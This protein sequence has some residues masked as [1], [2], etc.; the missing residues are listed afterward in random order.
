MIRESDLPP[1]SWVDV[2]TLA[3]LFDDCVTSYKYFFFLALLDRISGKRGG[4]DVSSGDRPILLRELAVDMVVAA[5]Y[6]HGFCRLSFGLQDR[7]QPA[8]DEVFMGQR[9]RGTWIAAGGSE[10]HR[11]RSVCENRLKPESFLQ[12]V[13]YRL[14]RP[15]FSRELRGIPDQRVNERIADMAEKCFVDRRPLYCFTGDR[16]GIILQH[17]WLEYLQRNAA[18]LEGWARFRLAEYLQAR[19]PNSPAVIEKI[20]PPT[21]RESLSV[22]TDYWRKALT[23][24]GDR[25]RCIYSG[26]RLDIHSFSLDHYLPWSFVCHNQL[27]NLVPTIGSINSQK[28]DSIPAVHYLAKL[29]ELHASALSV[30]NESRADG[31]RRR[32]VETYL[33]DLRLSPKELLDLGK[34][35]NAYEATI[36]PLAAIAERQGFASGWEYT[37]D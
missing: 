1:S 20:V 17:E 21:V 7:L 26:E 37:K 10:W 22:Q 16:T 34:V 15:F 14:L 24:L 23:R 2:G 6:P 33:T 9:I 11:L 36:S 28:S 30:L 25:A 13:P 8:V 35:R 5:W 4:I 31:R 29:A 3:R 12:Y 18:I 27:W 32:A 19:N